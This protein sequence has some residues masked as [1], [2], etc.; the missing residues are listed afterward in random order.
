MRPEYHM[1]LFHVL[2]I[3]ISHSLGNV[4]VLQP[5]ITPP[6]NAHRTQKMIFQIS[7]S[8][9]VGSSDQR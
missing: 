3:V 8:W 6:E 9:D 4:I 1:Q 7:T 2:T 5:K